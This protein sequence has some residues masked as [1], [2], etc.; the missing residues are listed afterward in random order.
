MLA[1]AR[2]VMYNVPMTIPAQSPV[3]LKKLKISI[4]Y[5]VDESGNIVSRMFEAKSWNKGP[6]LRSTFMET[7]GKPSMV[8]AAL[9]FDLERFRKEKKSS[10]I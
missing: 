1:L 5:R 3:K 9:T 6:V 4:E 10:K 8:L 7:T 2:M